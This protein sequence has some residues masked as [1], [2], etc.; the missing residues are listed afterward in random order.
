MYHSTLITTDFILFLSAETFQT[1]ET[2]DGFDDE[3]NKLVAVIEDGDGS[4]ERG[5]KDITGNFEL[6][7]NITPLLLWCV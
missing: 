1:G 2:I 6:E 5:S 4:V 3:L 7:P